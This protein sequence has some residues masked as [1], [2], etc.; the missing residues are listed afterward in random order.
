LVKPIYRSTAT[1]GHFGRK[2]IDFSWEKTDKAGV[3]K[4]DAGI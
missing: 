3:L 4:N 2:D 1:Y